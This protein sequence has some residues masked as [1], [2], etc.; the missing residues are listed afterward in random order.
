MGTP[1]T[2]DPYFK[3]LGIPR[4]EQPPN[5]YRLLGVNLFEG[6]R[7]VIE[8]GAEQR[9]NYLRTFQNGPSNEPSQKLLKEI[10]AARLCLLN[11]DRK[12]EYDDR[13]R[14]RLAIRGPPGIRLGQVAGLFPKIS[15]PAVEASSAV[16]RSDSFVNSWTPPCLSR[17]TL[18]TNDEPGAVELESLGISAEA[19]RRRHRTANRPPIIPLVGPMYF[20]VGVLL[21]ALLTS[22]AH[23]MIDAD[24]RASGAPHVVAADSSPGDGPRQQRTSDKEKTRNVQR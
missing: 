13:L 1:T 5:H 12:F 16:G 17:E 11:S 24:G 2:F 3:W 21:G 15:I 19:I 9:T 14:L 20:V 23:K 18:D 4:T 6:D 10:A 8:S 22:V 7:E